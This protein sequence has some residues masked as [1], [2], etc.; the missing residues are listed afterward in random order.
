MYPSDKAMERPEVKE[1]MTFVLA[2]QAEIAEAAKIVPMTEEQAA[3][4][5]E[6]VGAG[7]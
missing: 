1:F 6:K 4:S 7:T 3:A 5:T 2:N